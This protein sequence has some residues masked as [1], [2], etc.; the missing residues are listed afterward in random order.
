VEVAGLEEIWEVVQLTE[1]MVALE[2]SLL[3]VAGARE[4][5]KPEPQVLAVK[6]AVVWFVFFLGN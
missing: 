1:V 6:A 4:I 5:L 3:E 2:D